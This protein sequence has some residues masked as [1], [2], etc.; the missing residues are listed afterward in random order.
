LVAIDGFAAYASTCGIV[1]PLSKGDATLAGTDTFA[2]T[3]LAVVK[4]Q[5]FPIALVA[6]S[7]SLPDA[8]PNTYVAA[9]GHPN[10]DAEGIAATLETTAARIPAANVTVDGGESHCPPTRSHDLSV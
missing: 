6:A 10:V 5:S 7:G 2:R 1:I 3:G 8:D 9:A 4:G